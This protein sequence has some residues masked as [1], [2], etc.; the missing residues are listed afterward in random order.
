MEGRRPEKKEVIKGEG[1]G[2]KRTAETSTQKR[3]TLQA[4]GSGLR[5]DEECAE[6]SGERKFSAAMSIPSQKKSSESSRVEEGKN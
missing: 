6:G 3:S 2:G 1:G 4:E 5:S